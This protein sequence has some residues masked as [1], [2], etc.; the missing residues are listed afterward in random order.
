MIKSEDIK[1]AEDAMSRAMSM[2]TVHVGEAL[3]NQEGLLLPDV[4]KFF[5]QKLNDVPLLLQTLAKEKCHKYILHCGE[6][7]A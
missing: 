1:T 2:T 7:F 5:L 4:H 3:M 6:Q